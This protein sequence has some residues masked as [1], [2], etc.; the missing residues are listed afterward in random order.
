MSGYLTRRDP[1][2]K[3]GVALG[4]SLL[5]VL[6]IDP[7]TPLVF[8]ALASIAALAL[9]GMRAASLGRTLVPL[10]V[11]ALGFVWTNAVFA[12]PRPG[13]V[14][15]GLG[16]FRVSGSGLLF[17]L[18]IA[19]RGLAIG[20]LSI[21][22]VRTSDP[23]A[24]AASLVRNARV[25]YRLAY[26]L[27]AALRFFPFVGDEYQ[28]LGLARRMR[29]LAPRSPRARV[30]A[31]IGRIVP[32]LSDAAR[33]ATRLA[34]AMDARGFAGA[35]ARTAYRETPVTGADWIFVAVALAIAAAI[36]V[37]GGAF[38]WLRIWDGRF[39]A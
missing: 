9:G 25:P 2:M 1:A 38:G 30:E 23:A 14:P 26:A 19:M 11:V 15:V 18:G 34:V 21:V 17:G 5:L 32:L 6:V 37:A 36:V 12:V 35:T 16:P 22:A 24:L 13:D 27:L 33:R 3:L 10:L 4:L 8:L 39:S 31:F 28:Q 7:I 20:M 29:G